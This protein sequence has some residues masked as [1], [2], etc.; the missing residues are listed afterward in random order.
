MLFF[1]ENDNQIFNMCVLGENDNQIACVESL[2]KLP[3][4]LV[5]RVNHINDASTGTETIV[6]E[7]RRLHHAAFYIH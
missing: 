7:W 6:S 4:G 2:E 1:Q 5:A 3:C